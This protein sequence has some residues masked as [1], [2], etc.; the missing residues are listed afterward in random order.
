MNKIG[1][2]AGGG[3]FPL[4]FAQEA[5][6]IGKELISIALKGET[7]PQIEKI[8]NRTYWVNVGKL[9]KLIKVLKQEHVKEAVMAGRVRHTRLFTEVKLDLRAIKLLGKIENKKSDSILGAVA[10]ELENEGIKLLN[11]TIFLSSLLPQKGVISLRRPT[12]DEEKDIKFGFEIA[13]RIAGLDIGQTVVVKSRC[14]LAVEAL[15]GTDKCI[16]RGSQLG[17]GKVVVVKVAK[18]KQDMRFDVPVI[19]K[20]TIQV[21]TETGVSTLAIEENKTLILDKEEVI[22]LA[23]KSGISIVVI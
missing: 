1:L 15:E 4:I 20:R 8:V 9:G 14:V 17:K 21:L 5:K 19:G 2:I 10:Q 16:L 23:N 6:K 18:P 12:E 22:N 7:N 13:K 3:K 11:S